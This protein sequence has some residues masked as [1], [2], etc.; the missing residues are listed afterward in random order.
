MFHDVFKELITNKV[1]FQEMNI[2]LI[3]KY[4]LLDDKNYEIQNRHELTKYLDIY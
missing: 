4:N 2:I 1:K 3:N